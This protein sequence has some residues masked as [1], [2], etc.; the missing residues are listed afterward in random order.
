MLLMDNQARSIDMYQY[1]L[2]LAI[3]CSRYDLAEE[4]EY[5]VMTP[6]DEIESLYDSYNKSRPED[7]MEIFRFYLK[8]IRNIKNADEII[9]S[10]Y[11]DLFSMNVNEILPCLFETYHMDIKVHN[12]LQIEI[13][14][15]ISDSD[16]Q[17]LK[18]AV[19]QDLK[20][21]I[22]LKTKFYGQ[23]TNL[24]GI[25]SSTLGFYHQREKRNIHALLNKTG[26]NKAG[27]E[28][29][30][31]SSLNIEMLPMKKEISMNFPEVMKSIYVLNTDLY[32]HRAGNTVPFY[33]YDV[34]S[35]YKSL[36]LQKLQEK[37]GNLFSSV[38]KRRES[39]YVAISEPVDER[40]SGISE[41]LRKHRILLA[42]LQ[43]IVEF[44]LKPE[45]VN[46]YVRKIYIHVVKNHSGN[47]S[48]LFTVKPTTKTG[49]YDTLTTFSKLSG[50]EKIKDV[51]EGMVALNHLMVYIAVKKINIFD[52]PSEAF[53][54]KEFLYRFDTLE[55]VID[56]FE[57]INEIFL[58]K[59]EKEIEKICNANYMPLNDDVIN[60]IK[61]TDCD[62][63]SI[64]AVEVIPYL[65][66]LSDLKR[67]KKMSGSD[68]NR[69]I[70]NKFYSALVEM[71]KAKKCIEQIKLYLN[72]SSMQFS[73][74]FLDFALNMS[75]ED[76]VLSSFNIDIL[77]R[78]GIV[79]ELACVRDDTGYYK[80]PDDSFL[81]Y[82]Y[83]S[84]EI[85]NA[86]S[87]LHSQDI[88]S[89]D[90]ILEVYRVC[91]FV[92]SFWGILKLT[93]DDLRSFCNTFSSASGLTMG[94]FDAYSFTSRNLFICSI[95]SM[96]PNEAIKKITNMSGTNLFMTGRIG[97][98]IIYIQ[99][100]KI[101]RLFYS[102][103]RKTFLLLE[104]LADTYYYDFANKIG[105]GCSLT[106]NESFLQG[107]RRVILNEKYMCTNEHFTSFSS[108]CTRTV[109][110]YLKY[111]GKLVTK[112]K[113]GRTMVLHEYGLWV[114]MQEDGNYFID[115]TSEEDFLDGG[116][117]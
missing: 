51:L 109:D 42:E 55:E 56:L 60:I 111:H 2:I 117:M 12:M 25:I 22:K 88:E 41:K 65:G 94:F 100:E 75:F 80:I 82:C 44:G 30:N 78:Q 19:I 87:S 101:Y 23:G 62:D 39:S 89:P 38:F 17:L 4:F 71:D 64:A 96:T 84:K 14:R 63:F 48:S 68:K 8:D 91:A 20:D 52:I 36:Y 45:E 33:F 93:Y 31:I 90:A 103:F 5:L 47:A 61:N 85:A 86:I 66:S 34:L 106:G 70:F 105:G 79:A 32:L 1:R 59:E 115:Q 26:I 72:F 57:P 67:G 18:G 54:R 27:E 69:I 16:W 28:E 107:A 7:S 73:I 102:Y 98:N 9:Y 112:L 83:H 74:P 29:F 3:A 21:N 113:K 43:P 116:F 53:L 13:K 99:L 58:R 24:F 81:H 104:Q 92:V 114:G 49:H 77:K 46:E 6:F 10:T 76:D 40:N 108:R 110:G 37:I 95:S 15:K 11:H 50:H 35:Y 97:L